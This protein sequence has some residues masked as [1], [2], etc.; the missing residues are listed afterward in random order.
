[1]KIFLIS[2]MEITALRTRYSM[3]SSKRH[4]KV[5]RMFFDLFPL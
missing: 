3:V 4:F 2:F 1:M 5:F